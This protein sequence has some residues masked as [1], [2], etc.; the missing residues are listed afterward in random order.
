MTK[1]EK[2]LW[3]QFLRKLP[4][5]VLRQKPLDG[6]I[7]DFYCAKVKLV[8]EVDGGHHFTDNGIAYDQQRTKILESYGLKVIR[9]TNREIMDNFREVCSEIASVINRTRSPL[10]KGE[11]KAGD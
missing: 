1:A 4:V 3:H 8:I 6:F 9:F 7:V 5:T 10:R 11:P 2:K